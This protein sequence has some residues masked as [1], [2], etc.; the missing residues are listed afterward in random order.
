M[1]PVLASVVV[2][3]ATMIEDPDDLLATVIAAVAGASSIFGILQFVFMRLRISRCV[4][5]LP[6][7]IPMGFL[8]GIGLE[9]CS[10]VSLA[11]CWQSELAAVLFAIAL[12]LGSWWRGWSLSVLFVGLLSASVFLFYLLDGPD[13]WLLQLDEHEK[14]G[15]AFPCLWNPDTLQR[16]QWV[17]LAT[18]GWRDLIVLIFLGAFQNC[19]FAD[20]YSR[21]PGVSVTPDEVMFEFGTAFSVSGLAGFAGGFHNM[22]CISLGREL[23]SWSQSSSS[24]VAVLSCMMIMWTGLDILLK[25]PCFVFAGLLVWIGIK[26]LRTYFVQP[27]QMLPRRETAVLV[28][29]AGTM[30]VFGFFMGILVGMCLALVV[31]VATLGSFSCVQ[32]VS[33]GR[34]TRSNALR[35]SFA[36]ELLTQYGHEILVLRLAPGFVFFATSSQ[37]MELV[38]ERLRL[39]P[40]GGLHAMFNNARLQAPQTLF[41]TPGLRSV[42]EGM[43]LTDVVVDFTLCRGFDGSLVGILQQLG[44]LA[45]AKGFRLHFAGLPLTKERWLM[46]HMIHKTC[47]FYTDLDRGLECVEDSLLA[48]RSSNVSSPTVRLGSQH[49]SFLRLEEGSTSEVFHEIARKGWTLLFLYSDKSAASR[50]ARPLVAKVIQRLGRTCEIV[51]ASEEDCP[52]LVAE[53]GHGPSLTLVRDGRVYWSTGGERFVQKEV[54][55]DDV[56]EGIAKEVVNCIAIAVTQ[57]E[58]MGES[59]AALNVALQ[60]IRS[61]G[62]T[63]GEK[64]PW[65]TF[66]HMAGVQPG[67]VLDSLANVVE[68]PIDV[69]RGEVLMFK[70]EALDRI[71][72]VLSGSMSLWIEGSS[73]N[74]QELGAPGP[75][76]IARKV[77][78]DFARIQVDSS[79]QSSPSE[80]SVLRVKEHVMLSAGTLRFLHVGPGW[81]IGGCSAVTSGWQPPVA[82]FTCVA[83]TA[84][85]VFLLSNRHLQELRKSDPVSLLALQ[86]MLGHQ[87][88][89]QL[90]LAT[91][92]LSEWHALLFVGVADKK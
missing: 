45:S 74:Q 28:A 4:S 91:E 37:L 14:T 35:S 90:R 40:G 11:G 75:S 31:I 30:K 55:K 13:S 50:G 89:V 25:V 60:K 29:V 24:I 54:S 23:G 22:A 63:C 43:S 67:G 71:Y 51:E 41:E 36:D 79:L 59:E 65:H 7:S 92:R 82:S 33:S 83:E 39:Q 77:T 5:Y 86:E 57:T 6:Y 76:S 32:R 70:G 10:S 19:L 81:A 84:S 21:A 42:S 58:G 53:F 73:H 78:E 18:I 2:K 8:S 88:S 9:L 1:A 62:A 72:C 20:V 26:F 16:V 80:S 47:F 66:L 38:E 69:G 3:L 56:A 44:A 12:C 64:L 48:R 85:R 49:V 52:Q 15:L 34:E 87:S 68:N 61:A 46:K 17:E 27:A